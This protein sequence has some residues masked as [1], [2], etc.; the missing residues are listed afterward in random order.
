MQAAH[1]VCKINRTTKHLHV[2]I[3]ESRFISTNWHILIRVYDINPWLSSDYMGAN[4]YKLMLIKGWKNTFRPSTTV[5]KGT[6]IWSGSCWWAIALAVSNGYSWNFLNRFFLTDCY[7]VAADYRGTVAQ[8]ETGED[9]Q[10]W[11][12][13]SPHRHKYHDDHLFPDGV[14]AANKYCRS[15]DKDSV[16]WCYTRNRRVRWGYCDIPKCG[17]IVFKI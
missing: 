4:S 5:V 1:Q 9:C 15:P 2:P 6:L 16:P 17:G 7:N 13:D 14:S 10:L 11:S 3:C 8:T 12:R